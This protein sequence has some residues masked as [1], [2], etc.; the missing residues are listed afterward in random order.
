[1][2]QQVKDNLQANPQLLSHHLVFE[3]DAF[4]GIDAVFAGQS[5]LDSN[6]QGRFAAYWAQRDG[7]SSSMA[8]SEDLTT[9]PPSPG[10]RWQLDCLPRGLRSVL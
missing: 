3:P 2:N 8:V 1:M 5:A 6:A 4:D 7:Q 9:S 10:I